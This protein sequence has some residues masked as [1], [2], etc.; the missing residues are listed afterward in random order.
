MDQSC[1]IREKYQESVDYPIT[2]CIDEFGFIIH[3]SGEPCSHPQN[4]DN[5]ITR[6]EWY[7]LLDKYET[8]HREF[9]EHIN[10]KK[11]LQRGI[12]ILLRGRIWKTLLF[13]ESC[14]CMNKNTDNLYK[15]GLHQ[16]CSV[17]RL[18]YLNIKPLRQQKEEMKKYLEKSQMPCG[19]E[20]QIHV[21]VQRTFR[22][23]YLFFNSYGKG[24]AELFNMLVA[25]ANQFKEIG[26][27]QGMSDIAAIFLMQYDEIE[28]YQMMVR[29]FKTNKLV[30]IFDSNFTRLPQLIKKQIK[31]LQ[32]VIPETYVM[33]KKHLP[34]VEMSIVA[35]YLTFFTRFNIRLCLRIWDHMMYHGFESCLYFVCAIFKILGKRFKDLNEEQVTQL[36]SR[37]ELEKID[38]N[39]VVDLATLFI[40]GSKRS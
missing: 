8:S 35:W 30:R 18:N 24:Q 15:Q 7:N 25:F 13:K 23:H 11:L 32:R 39:E 5:R 26:Y 16:I 10:H 19:Y 21:D 37:I 14:C 3:E 12:P 28:A 1:Q 31:L 17:F 27:C 2:L 9:K 29:F 38:E 34:N 4:F 20:Y 36:L 6:N 22:R 33:L 40:A